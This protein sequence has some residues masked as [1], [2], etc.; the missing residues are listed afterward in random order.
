MECEGAECGVKGM[1]DLSIRTE[2]EGVEWSVKEWNGVLRS[3]AWCERNGMVCR[4][5]R[6][7]KEWNGV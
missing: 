6:S 4:L 7:V 2:C 1:D 3:G 5:E